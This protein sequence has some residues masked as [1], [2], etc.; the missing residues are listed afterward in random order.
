MFNRL[1]IVLVISTLIAAC[2]NKKHHKVLVEEKEVNKITQTLYLSDVTFS[3][4]VAD[5]KFKTDCAMLPVLRKSILDSSLSHSMNIS[6]S[7]KI[8]NEQYELKV[9][10]VNVVPHRWTFMAIRPSSNATIKASILK[11]DATLHTTTKLIGSAVAFGACDRLEKI[12]IAE[13]RYISK[14]VSKFI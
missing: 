12:S 11:G 4:E 6:S 1:I 7:N 13:G 3:K 10:Y 5:G 14:W 2:S 8:G 9:E